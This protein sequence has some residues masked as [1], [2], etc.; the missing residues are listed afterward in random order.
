MQNI[1]VPTDF[2]TFSH[3]ALHYALEIAYTSGAKIFLMHALYKG[4]A[5]TQASTENLHQFIEISHEKANDDFKQYLQKV[6]EEYSREELSNMPLEYI[7]MEGFAVDQIIELSQAQH[8]DLL[9]IGTKGVSGLRQMFFGS[10]TQAIIERTDVPVLAVPIEAQSAEI[11]NIVIAT[12]LSAKAL[13]AIG[14]IYD[15]AQFLNAR[16]KFLHIIVE[17]TRSYADRLEQFLSSVNE[18]LGEDS[19][20]FIEMKARSVLEGLDAYTKENKVDILAMFRKKQSSLNDFFAIS[21]TEKMAFHGKVPVL[22]FK[23]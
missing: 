12:D 4:Y 23:S 13:S 7:L 8:F 19:Y 11:E 5:P 2:S 22:I 6:Q 1:L 21:F 16:L 15:I 10:N 9:I 20:D 18:I 14:K 17:E 3:N